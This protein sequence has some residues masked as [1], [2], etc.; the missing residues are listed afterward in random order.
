MRGKISL[1]GCAGRFTPQED[2]LCRKSYSAGR[3]TPPA[4][5]LCCLMKE[6]MKTLLYLNPGRPQHMLMAGQTK[7]K[8]EN[9]DAD[10]E[11]T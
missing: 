2:L 8:Q 7:D 3:V 6:V 5:L 11:K 10:R 1:Y 9:G 4:D